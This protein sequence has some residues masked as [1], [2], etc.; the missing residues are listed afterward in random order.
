MAPL[1]DENQNG[2]LNAQKARGGGRLVRPEAKGLSGRGSRRLIAPV[3]EKIL[4]A[5]NSL[6]KTRKERFR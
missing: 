4:K 5:W 2:V 6:Q 3:A 1:I